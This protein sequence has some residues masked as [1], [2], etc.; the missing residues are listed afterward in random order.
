MI[1]DT[2]V[3]VYPPEV[4]TDWENIARNENYFGELVRGRAHKWATAE[5]V[6]I[7][8]DRDGVDQ[9]WI[10]GFGFKD[11]GLCRL[12]ND[13]AATAAAKSGG[14]LKALGV[15]PPL[16]KG[17][18]AEIER[19]AGLGMI[20]VG[21]IFP[22]GQDFDISDM[23][24]TWRF[25]ASCDENGLFALVHV[26][27][28][29]GRDYPGKGFVGPQEAYLLARNHPE[30]MIVFAHFGGG[31]FFYETLRGAG[32]VLKNV[33]YDTAAAP[34][35]YGG[36]I[37]DLCS[38]PLLSEKIFYG[39]DFPLLRYERYK[40]MMEMSGISGEASERVL[41]RNAVDFLGRIIK[42]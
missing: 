30:L 5:E 39:S 34:F 23:S 16:A 1:I 29:I 35:V 18:T 20:G 33:R 25:A 36:E 9:S 13:Y 12:C 2:H 11:I 10:F 28:P 40:V 32:L 15:I 19:C 31:L 41:S 4:I 17:A 6:V 42:N 24:E 37:F 3:H 14:R 26:S 7:S 27:E 8:M 38:S 22:D 21:E